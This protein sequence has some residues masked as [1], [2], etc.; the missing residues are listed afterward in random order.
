M[1]ISKLKSQL[2]IVFLNCDINEFFKKY[3]TSKNLS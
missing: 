3:N 2:I 1:S